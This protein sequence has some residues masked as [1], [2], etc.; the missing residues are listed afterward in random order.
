[1]KHKQ[2]EFKDSLNVFYNKLAAL[3]DM[4]DIKDAVK[5]YF[6]HYFNNLPN[7]NYRGAIPEAKYYSIDE[8]G[9]K[10]RKKVEEWY[11]ATYV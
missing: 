1:M 2:I 8:I 11:I 7:Q 6:P 9:L 10:G 4:F 5:G 3:R